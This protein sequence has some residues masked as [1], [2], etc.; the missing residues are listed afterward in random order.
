LG[1]FQIEYLEI[2]IL[3][4]TNICWIQTWFDIWSEKCKSIPCIRKWGSVYLACP[5]EA[6]K[7][8]NHIRPFRAQL[9]C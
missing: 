7:S 2:F 5:G 4:I 3:N 9:M 8:Y 1:N 6:F